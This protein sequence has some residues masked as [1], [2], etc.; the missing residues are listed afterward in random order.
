MKKVKTPT[1]SDLEEFKKIS[2]PIFEDTFTNP[3][4]A[5][6]ESSEE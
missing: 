4:I 2:I 6:N 5:C 3:N 1:M